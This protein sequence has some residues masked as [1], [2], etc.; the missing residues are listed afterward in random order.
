M[1]QKKK[2]ICPMDIINT[3][4][5]TT[6]I[7]GMVADYAKVKFGKY[8][9]PQFKSQKEKATLHQQA[10]IS[11]QDF[12]VAHPEMPLYAILSC[13]ISAGAY[14]HENFK[15]GY[16]NFNA[17]KCATILEMSKEYCKAM[18]MKGKP[19]DVVYRLCAKFYNTVSTDIEVFKQRLATAT[20]MDG[21][22]GHY[23]ELCANIG[24]A[25]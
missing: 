11:V 24:M 10:C 2:V 3:D 7:K 14:K 18:G 16:K 8:H 20:P 13:G 9:L 19:T 6:D 5:N 12:Q 22:R 17:D 15:N 21:K 1:E 25:V 23:K 4:V